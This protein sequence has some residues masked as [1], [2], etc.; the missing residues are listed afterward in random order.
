MARIT[1]AKCKLC[2]R[3]GEKLFLRGTRCDDSNKCAFDRRP[4][5]PGVHGERRVRMTDYG[6]HLRE[7]QKAK[8][9]YGLMERQFRRYFDTA[10]RMPGNTGDNLIQILESRLDNV[11]YRLG[12]ATSRNQ[13]RQLILHGHVL[14]NEKRVSV[15]SQQVKA[16]DSVKPATPERSTKV[17]TEIH[18]TFDKGKIPSW[19]SL[20]EGPLTG[21]VVNLPK[22]ED[23]AIP[24][25]VQLIVEFCSK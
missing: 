11:V 15:P 23:L 8:R 5:P 7:K 18:K 2:R 16:A 21:R 1:N 3:E 24:L 19:L 14:V 9:I 17:V 13:A 20:T 6:I 22:R 25:D 10:L 4:K 12:F